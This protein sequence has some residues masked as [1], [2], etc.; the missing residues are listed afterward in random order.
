MPFSRIR[1]YVDWPLLCSVH[2]ELRS[3]SLRNAKIR[4]ATTPSYYFQPLDF[5]LQGATP[6]QII[7]FKL[8]EDVQLRIHDLMARNANEGLSP[9]EKLEVEQ[10]LDIEHVMTLLNARALRMVRK[11]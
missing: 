6:Q 8:S 9:E 2:R 1:R 3:K 7:D 10:F 4:M 11:D 5:V